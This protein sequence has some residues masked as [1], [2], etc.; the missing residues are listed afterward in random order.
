MTPMPADA[1]YVWRPAQP[2]QPGVRLNEPSSIAPEPVPE[3]YRVPP[4]P[5]S[6]EPPN[7]DKVPNNGSLPDG[8]RSPN[9]DQRQLTPAMPADIA[10]FNPVRE[11]IASGLRPGSMEGFNWLNSKG[12]QAVL[13]LHAPDVSD[14]ADRKVVES[15]GMKF[16]SLSVTPKNLSPELVEQFFRIVNDAGN[17]PLFVYDTNGSLVG[18]LW[19]L[20]FRIVDRMD[21]EEAAR[22]AIQLGLKAV[23][24]AQAAD[25][26]YVEMWDAVQTYMRDAATRDCP[27]TGIGS[28]LRGFRKAWP[29]AFP[30]TRRMTLLFPLSFHTS[31]TTHCHYSFANHYLRLASSISSLLKPFHKGYSEM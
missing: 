24:D 5:Q 3:R 22:K 21:S 7:A 23:K 11:R 25:A 1:G 10:L 14:D 9:T 6:Q 20:Y 31:N 15:R 30:A 13:Y 26:P 8:D 4:P 28:E 27:K 18:G 29:F 12:Y 16:L 2:S 19:F 17:Q